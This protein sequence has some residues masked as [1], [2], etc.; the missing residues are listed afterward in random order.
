[1]KIKICGITNLEDALAAVDCGADMLG[2]NFYP[3]SPRYISIDQCALICEALAPYRP[4]LLLVG[5]FVNFTAEHV[6]AILTRCCLDLAQL[7]GDEPPETLDRLD[8]SAFKG[9]RPADQ[10]ELAELLDRYSPAPHAPAYLV[11]A[12]RPGAYGGSGKIADWSLAS[13]LAVRQPILLAG[14]LTPENVAEAVWTVRPWGVDVASGVESTPGRKDVD[15]IRRFIQ[16][17]ITGD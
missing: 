13:S 9:L 6:Q 14:G 7:S 11:D 4:G 12:N 15:K 3:P 1:M 16:A 8:S 2:F 17:A 10:E 5:V